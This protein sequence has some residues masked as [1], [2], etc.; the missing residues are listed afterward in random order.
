MECFRE[1]FALNGSE[2]RVAA[3]TGIA[4]YPVDGDDADALFKNAEAALKDARRSSEPYLFY[5]AEM[6]ARAAQALSLE[7]RLRKA[8][9]EQQFVLHYQPKILLTTKSICGVEALLRWQEPGAGLVPPGHFIPLLEETRL[10]LAVG[11]WALARAL[12]DHRV[13][14]AHG[15]EAP[16]VAVNLSSIQ[17]DRRDFTDTVM[18]V[19]EQH[20]DDPDVLELEITESVLMTDVQTSTSKLS[21][22]R[23]LGVRIAMDDFGTGY[24]SLSYIARLPIDSLKIDR[25]FIAAMPR[26]AQDMAIVSAIITLA[27]SLNLKVVAEGVETAE[28]AKLLTLLKCNEA[29]GFLYSKP[30]PASEIERILP[31]KRAMGGQ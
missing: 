26:N 3:K 14:M 7:T 27:H 28:Q 1:P 23:G 11:K 24:S 8:V 2:L 13:W 10:I 9:E 12:A 16:R 20:G 21:N 25:S 31:A 5:A 19:L 29:Q 18:E 22:L 17:L 30:V 15:L 4:L 6:N